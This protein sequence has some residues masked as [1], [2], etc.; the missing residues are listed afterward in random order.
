MLYLIRRFEIYNELY[1]E[2]EGYLTYDTET[3]KY[4]MKVV[5]VAEHP[6]IYFEVLRQRGIVDVPEH[7]VDMWVQGRVLPPNRQGLQGLLE[8]IG[9][10]EYNV[11]DLLV[12][13][14]AR[15]QMDYDCIRELDE[16]GNIKPGYVRCLEH[17]V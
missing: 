16:A 8:K 13:G 15:N 4:A 5:D 10:H 9:M 17:C 12:Y 3:G 14:S 2:V 7:L 11:F 6:S 1:E